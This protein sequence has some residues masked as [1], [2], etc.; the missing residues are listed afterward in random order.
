VRKVHLKNSPKVLC[1]KGLQVFVFELKCT[2]IKRR[3]CVLMIQP[4][5]SMTPRVGFRGTKGASGD[6]KFYPTPG[7]A[8]ANAAGLSLAAGGVTTA[9]ARMYTQSWP[10]ASTLGVFGTF[11]T[12]F[13][14]TPQLIEKFGLKKTVKGIADD[15]VTKSEAKKTVDVMKQMRP[16][17]KLVPF[18]QQS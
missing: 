7:V 18:R 14:M 2:C 1:I 12:L 4:I 3:K 16:A 11:I 15:G 9:V 5:S 6:R 17:K 10:Q 13:F 8:L